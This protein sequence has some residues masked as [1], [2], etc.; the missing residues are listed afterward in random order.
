MGVRALL[1][2][3]VNLFPSPLEI[4]VPVQNDGKEG[5]LK[6]DPNGP[7]VAFVFKL[8]ADPYVGRVTVFRVFSGTIKSDSTVVNVTTGRKERIGQLMVAQGKTYEPI[9]EAPAA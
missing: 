8:Y 3:I 7:G 1:D 2:A 6:P 4:T 5:S 9:G